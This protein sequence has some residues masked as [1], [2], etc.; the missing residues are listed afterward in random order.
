VTHL[1]T[2]A[3][4]A[5]A[6]LSIRAART[7]PASEYQLATGDVIEIAA[8]G[9]PDI[10]SKATVDVDGRALFPLIGPVN[11]AGLT[12]SQ[13][14][15]NVRERLPTKVFR[16][17]SEDGREY[18]IVLTPDEVLVSIAE[19]R[20]I[21]LN[22]DVA[23]PGPQPYRPGL[24]VRQAIAMAGGFDVMRFR[25]KD[26][27][28]ESSDL[29]GE[30]D[31]QWIE[32][33][34]EQARMHSLREVLGKKDGS[35]ADK[36]QRIPVPQSVIADI[37][38]LEAERLSASTTDY[39]KEKTHLATTIQKETEHIN[40]LVTERDKEKQDADGDAAEL[41]A[42]QTNLQKGIVPTTR[43]AEARRLA[44]YSATRALQT[45]A[46]IAQIDAQ[47]HELESRLDRIDDQRRVKLLEEL[48]NSSVKLAE[49][50]ARLQAVGEKL[51]YAGMVR[52]QLVRGGGDRPIVTIF[53][54]NDPRSSERSADNDSIL[55]PGDVVEVAARTVGQ[56]QN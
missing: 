17:R 21:Y 52:S 54:G 30:Y 36:A 53:R 32:F 20:P 42:T 29:K 12:I 3:I 37:S 18:P 49:I 56:E 26:P 27:F 44:F 46:L 11:A 14:Q 50:S 25:A 55:M 39:Q 2:W 45:S 19:Y 13:I 38:R 6:V 7:E 28:L 48:Q 9:A 15:A 23:K 51:M 16:R 47:R 43:V 33:A 4:V 1:R 8:I 22:G 34:R 35:A 41:Q 24:T 31:S 5:I 10:R 40:I